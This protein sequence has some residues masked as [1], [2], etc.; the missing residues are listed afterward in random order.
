MFRR[1]HLEHMEDYFYSQSE[2]REQGVYFTR[3]SSYSEEI[4]KNIER[5]LEQTLEV[6]VCVEGKIGNPEGVQLSYYEEV[7]GMEYRLDKNF[8]LQQLEKWMP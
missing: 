8:F 2:R 6:G 1:I 3:L 4:Q 5:Y 7:M